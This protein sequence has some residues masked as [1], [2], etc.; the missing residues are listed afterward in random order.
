MT[1][2]VTNISKNI[3]ALDVADWFIIK[4]S[5]EEDFTDMTNMKVNKLCYYAFCLYYR[6]KKEKLFNE[7]IEARTYGPVIMEV[8][9]KFSCCGRN[10]II[11]DREEK[12]FYS[13][14]EKSQIT[15]KQEEILQETYNNFMPYTAYYLR[16]MSHEDK[17]WKDT[18]KRLDI[19]ERHLII[20]DKKLFDFAL[21]DE[22]GEYLI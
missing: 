8:Y 18:Y 1:K 22:F 16:K 21:S 20:D 2:K 13:L 15:E 4:A 5:T 10:E 17:P 3:S 6:R 14:K 11:V 19:N 7:K 12:D 9:N